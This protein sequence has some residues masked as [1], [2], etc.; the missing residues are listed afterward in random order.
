MFYPQPDYYDDE[1]DDLRMEAKAERQYN[2]RLARHPN[3]N[4]PDHPGCEACEG[5]DDE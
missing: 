5:D 3:C 2:N 4:D 1:L